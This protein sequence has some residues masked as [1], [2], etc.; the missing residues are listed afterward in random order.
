M[1]NDPETKIRAPL[2]QGKNAKTVP[3]KE[4]G[5]PRSPRKQKKMAATKQKKILGPEIQKKCPCITKLFATNLT[6]LLDTVD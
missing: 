5:G 1:K 6:R 4:K 3:E 2:P